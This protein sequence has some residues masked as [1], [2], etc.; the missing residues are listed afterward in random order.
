MDTMPMPPSPPGRGTPSTKK[1]S[2]LGSI[3]PEPDDFTLNNGPIC[4]L[5]EELLEM[6]I[7]FVVVGPCSQRWLPGYCSAATIIAL[8]CKQLRRIVVPILYHTISVDQIE[9]GED[10]ARKVHR[11]LQENPS[12]REHCKE[13]RIG[14][15]H[16]PPT[17]EHLAILTDFVSWLT[18]VT[19]LA[20]EDP[21]CDEERDSWKLIQNATVQLPELDTFFL[22]PTWNE[23]YLDHIIQSIDSSSLRRL[24][25][26]QIDDDTGNS[27]VLTPENK[28]TASFSDLTLQ[29]YFGPDLIAQ[30]IQWPKT[31]LH[32]HFHPGINTEHYFDFPMFEPWLLQHKHTL[33]SIA[34]GPFPDM[35]EDRMFNA[36]A[37]PNL[38]YLGLSRWHVGQV[39]EKLLPLSAENVDR[40]LGPSLTTLMW[41]FRSLKGVEESWGDFGKEEENWV[42]RLVED[43]VSRKAALKHIHIIFVREPSTATASN[44]YP[45]DRMD[46]IGKDIEPLGLTLTYVPPD[47]TKKEWLKQVN[48]PKQD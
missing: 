37:F 1:Q 30:L 28:R 34:F 18:S 48:T 38:E 25:V 19:V 7:V 45:Y 29:N 9:S 14:I 27:T 43:A 10:R 26:N 47:L 32:F 31:L 44:G 5:P 15:Y 39:G 11:T 46:K 2:S 24:I 42:R 12:L 41:D 8:V 36:S 13:L 4:R 17:K 40:L 3:T 16:K 21:V 35:E 20:I 33:L 23:S 6:I 22:I